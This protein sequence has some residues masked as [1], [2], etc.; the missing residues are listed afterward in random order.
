MTPSNALPLWQKAPAGG[1]YI[2]VG[3]ERSFVG[4]ANT[5]GATHLL[6]T[7]VAPSVLVYNQI[8]TGLLIMAKDRADYLRLR[9]TATNEEWIAE[10]KEKLADHPQL[11]RLFVEGRLQNFWRIV[12]FS[13]M[14][15]FTRG[16]RATNKI[17]GKILV[18]GTEHLIPPPPAAEGA[19]KSFAQVSYLDNDM[20][21]KKLSAMAKAGRISVH[22]ADLGR[23]RDLN[24]VSNFLSR[25]GVRISVIDLSNAWLKGFID[26]TDFIVRTLRNHSMLKTLVIGSRGT[27]SG[28]SE[29]VA[30]TYQFL[31][32]AGFFSSVRA[33]NENLRRMFEDSFVMMQRMVQK[34]ALNLC[35][36]LLL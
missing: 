35:G 27:R 3:T 5:P 25:N 17:S 15:G 16:T 36:A 21:F 34:S 20:Q 6:M 7:D 2:S 12:Q 33:S 1:A 24:E 8:N 29:Y 31:E 32:L 14:Q 9:F 26:H 4:S 19:L 11:Q 30:F 18:R 28:S 22:R 10:A 13:D 23:Q